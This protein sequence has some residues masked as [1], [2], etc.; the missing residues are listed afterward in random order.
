MAGRSTGTAIALHRDAVDTDQIV[1]AEFCERIT[2]SGYDAL[3][4]R[5]R[6]DPDF[7]LNRTGCC[8][9]NWPRRRSGSWPRWPTPNSAPS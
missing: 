5:W 2:K 3:F 9:W 4:V 1:P 8:R 6:Q 7:P